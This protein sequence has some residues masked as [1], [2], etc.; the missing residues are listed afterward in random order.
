M[1]IFFRQF[2][3]R[4]TVAGT[5]WAVDI[6]A[7]ASEH[8][9]F[10]ISLW[11]GAWGTQPGTIVWSALV[12]GVA[13]LA[14]LNDSLMA[15]EAYLGKVAAAS[16]VVESVETDRV[17]EIVHGELTDAAEVGSYSGNVMAV[18]H[19]GKVGAAGAWAAEIADI[20]SATTGLPVIV[21][22]T[23]AGPIGEYGWFVRHADAA[24]IDAANA[25]IMASPD[26]IAAL[27]RSA[28]LFQPGAIQRYARRIA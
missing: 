28:G 4:G 10:P 8:A 19:E 23:T 6:T 11:V 24:S 1:Q 2:G 5:A 9:T 3:L 16:D 12:D 13:Q 14:E 27:D 21:T 22:T 17:V 7:K 26:Y 18:A 25:K 20:W 15:D